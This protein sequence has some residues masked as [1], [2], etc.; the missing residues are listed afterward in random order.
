VPKN[1]EPIAIVPVQSILRPEPHKTLAVLQNTIDKVLRQAVIN[2]KSLQ[3]RRLT[4]EIAGEKDKRKEYGSTMQ[5]GLNKMQ[6]SG[7]EK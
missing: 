7:T 5:H 6:L 3:P 2:G 4:G 1:R